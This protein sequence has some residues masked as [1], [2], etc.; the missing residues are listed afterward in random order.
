MRGRVGLAVLALS[1]LGYPLTRIVIKRGGLAGL[2]VVESVCCGLAMRDAA[3]VRSGLARRL[4][5]GP[6][7]LP[8]MELGAAIAA[9][10]SGALSILGARRRGRSASALTI[11]ASKTQQFAIAAL[12]V[13]HTIRFAIYLQPD[14]GLA[15]GH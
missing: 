1:A 3:L 5:R 13:L 14:R 8:L 2:L 10:T 4:R 6:A 12:F 15:P 11:G 7:A 9:G